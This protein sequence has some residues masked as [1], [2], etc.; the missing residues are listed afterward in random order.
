[1]KKLSRLGILIFFICI[2]FSALAFA[3]YKN[4]YSNLNDESDNNISSNNSEITK[5]IVVSY[6]NSNIRILFDNNNSVS[7]ELL[8]ETA[9]SDD[10]SSQIE[11]TNEDIYQMID[12]L[13][14][15][16]L[17][18]PEGKDF[19]YCSPAENVDI[20]LNNTDLDI[21]VF[22][23]LSEINSNEEL[24]EILTNSIIAAINNNSDK[25]SDFFTSY[26]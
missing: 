22:K 7:A 9:Y 19:K 1:M 25:L 20:N 23:E 12:Y 17:H 26:M 18:I 2:V 3:G 11:F 8:S 5:E 24:N 15:S 6:K 16:S 10:T 4:S 14:L 13:Q 21:A